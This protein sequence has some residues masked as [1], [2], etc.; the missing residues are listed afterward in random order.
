MVARGREDKLLPVTCYPA[1]RPTCRGL[2]WNP[3]MRAVCLHVCMCVNV[4]RLSMSDFFS[5][6]SVS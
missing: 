1:C 4:Q 6:L 3:C 5:F 2:D